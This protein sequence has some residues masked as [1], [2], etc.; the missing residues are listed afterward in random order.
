ILLNFLL[1]AHN[2]DVHCVDWNPLDFNYILIGYVNIEIMY[3]KMKTILA[4]LRGIGGV[5]GAQIIK[6]ILVF[7]DGGMRAV[8]LV[9]AV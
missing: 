2:G 3:K 8:P 5:E 9:G 1:K 7:E 6:K 4:M